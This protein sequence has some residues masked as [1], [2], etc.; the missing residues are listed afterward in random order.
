MRLSLASIAS[1]I[2]LVVGSCYLALMFYFRTPDIVDL[3]LW[4]SGNSWTLG[5]AEIW[6]LTEFVAGK[7]YDGVAWSALATVTV[8]VQNLV[9]EGLQIDSVVVTRG[10]N[11]TPLGFCSMKLPNTK[12]LLWD[13]PQ[14]IGVS[15]NCLPSG[16]LSH[17]IKAKLREAINDRHLYITVYSNRGQ[18]SSKVTGYATYDQHGTFSGVVIQ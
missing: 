17:D 16:P 18:L 1:I 7:D 10:P 2:A 6:T 12:L 5:R 14:T 4:I 15:W 11:G 13:P 9:S 3:G 8:E